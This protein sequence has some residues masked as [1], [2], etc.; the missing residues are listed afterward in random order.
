MSGLKIAGH[1]SYSDAPGDGRAWTRDGNCEERVLRGGSWYS[2]VND[3]RSALRYGGSAGYR[4]GDV[5]FRI[6]RTLN[7]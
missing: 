7:P 4:G 3:L 5:G 2:N 1:N 6:A